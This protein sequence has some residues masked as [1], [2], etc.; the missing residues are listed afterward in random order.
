[1]PVVFYKHVENVKLQNMLSL[2]TFDISGGLF[3][4]SLAILSEWV[5][6]WESR[7]RYPDGNPHQFTIGTAL[8]GK[9]LV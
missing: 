2:K 8:N 4:I 3:L 1:M 7:V 6:M 5:S 9:A